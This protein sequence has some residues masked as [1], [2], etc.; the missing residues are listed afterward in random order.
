MSIK[1]GATTLPAASMVCLRGAASRSPFEIADGGYVA[2]EDADLARVPG[3]TGAVDNVAVDDNRVEGPAKRAGLRESRQ[4][5]QG[6]KWQ[7]E[8]S[9]NFHAIS[10]RDGS[11]LLSSHVGH[12]A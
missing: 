4:R 10:H 1:P 5:E 12:V 7:N 9:R 11:G 2:I 6:K 8:A 3:G